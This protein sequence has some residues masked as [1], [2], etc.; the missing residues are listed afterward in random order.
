[1]LPSIFLT[2]I[3]PHH[4]KMLGDIP[5]MMRSPQ[6]H[7]E[8]SH[9]LAQKWK[10]GKTVFHDDFGYGVVINTRLEEE[11]FVV[12]VQ[13]QTGGEKQFMPEYQKDIFLVED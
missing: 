5:Y 12:L 4:V 1:M 10:K 9:P 11:E 8:T 2:E 13:F 6:Q 3:K 7:Q